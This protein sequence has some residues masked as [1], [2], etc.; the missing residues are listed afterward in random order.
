[1]KEILPLIAFLVILSLCLPMRSDATTARILDA[2]IVP[3]QT[4]LP[5]P[6]SALSRSTNTIPLKPDAAFGILFTIDG[7]PEET[8]PTMI[9]VRLERPTASGER[10][11]QSWFLPVLP[12]QTILAPYS[13]SPADWPTVLTPGDWQ[14]FIVSEGAILA[15]KTLQL[16]AEAAPKTPPPNA[17]QTVSHTKE[18]GKPIPP[19]TKNTKKYF[20]QAGA[21]TKRENA[22]KMIKDLQKKGI[23]A[24]LITGGN[25][26]KYIFVSI[27]EYNTEAEAKARIQRVTREQNMEALAK[28][29]EPDQK[30][31]C[32]PQ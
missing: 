8:S 24:C 21:F 27:G 25:A 2:G 16:V 7:S 13:A 28:K 18:T 1:M 32:L 9:E 3:P 15:S 31:E 29:L 30:R 12:G 4:H 10:E 26:Q 6:G 19:K 17:A 5:G 11:T 20:V 14:F 22:V 23:S